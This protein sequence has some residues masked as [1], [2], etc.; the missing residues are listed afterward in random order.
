MKEIEIKK[1]VIRALRSRNAGDQNELNSKASNYVNLIDL[2]REFR[3]SAEKGRFIEELDRTL[4]HK[5]MPLLKP[6]VLQKL[7]QRYTVYPEIFDELNFYLRQTHLKIANE[8]F[9]E[10]IIN[11]SGVNP[12]TH[13]EQRARLS[14]LGLLHDHLNISCDQES[15]YSFVKTILELRI[16]V[17]DQKNLKLLLKK[18]PNSPYFSLINRIER[19]I[20]SDLNGLQINELI[21]RHFSPVDK[22]MSYSPVY[23]R[24]ISRLDTALPEDYLLEFNRGDL[25]KIVTVVHMRP[26]LIDQLPDMC[27]EEISGFTV[28]H[29]LFTNFGISPILRH[30]YFD[31]RMN[32]TEQEWFFH[33]LQGK[34][35]T[36]APNLPFQ[37]TKRMAHTYQNLDDVYN[38]SATQSLVFSAFLTLTNDM[39]YS[40]SVTRTVWASNQLEFWI[41]TMTILHRNGLREDNARE[42]ID[43][44]I[45]RVFRDGVQINFK[46]K[47]LSNLLQDIENWHTELRIK[48]EER[49]LRTQKLVDAGIP[50]KMIE[51]NDHKYRIFQLTRSNELFEEGNDLRHCVYS[52]KYQCR[53]G[54]SFI[55]SMR[56]I[57]DEKQEKRLITIEVVNNEIVQAKGHRNRHPT[58]EEKDIIR[59]WAHEQMILFSA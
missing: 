19:S 45:Q 23:R 54:K 30:K 9:I 38:L 43:Y 4:S 40:H 58:Q 20:H 41:K 36:S 11:H 32:E 51:L 31:G 16:P 56:Q 21:K 1:E 35:L 57:L 7:M 37:L 39:P 3:S 5:K 13:K 28:F 26:E 34:N 49:Y 42:V 44:I 12:C 24:L 29:A 18:D 14:L 22:E 53:K 15:T 59:L 25:K 8:K 33:V 55:Y 47:K 10:L 48:R 2:F 50:E 27:D 17:E 52:Y 6:A 46:R